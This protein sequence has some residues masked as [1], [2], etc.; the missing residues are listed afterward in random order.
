MTSATT[1]L[2]FQLLNPN[3]TTTFSSSKPIKTIKVSNFSS[4]VSSKTKISISCHKLAQFVA[5]DSD[6]SQQ[7]TQE[8]EP[9]EAVEDETNEEEGEV[10]EE[11]YSEPPEEA[12]LFVG[13]LPYDYDSEKLAQLF[14]SSGTVDIAEVF[15]KIEFF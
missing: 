7:V 15:L 13:N 12:K 3:C 11:T 8:S 14:N 2:P 4:W 6:W 1:I 5:K 10:E 9:V